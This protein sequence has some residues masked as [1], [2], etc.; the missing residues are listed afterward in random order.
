MTQCLHR[1]NIAKDQI[2]DEALAEKPDPF[3][4]DPMPLMHDAMLAQS[5]RALDMT[6]EAGLEVPCSQ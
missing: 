3:V 4:I 5:R 2:L 1:D 6:R